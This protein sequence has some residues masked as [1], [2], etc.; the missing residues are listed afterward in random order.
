MVP[1]DIEKATGDICQ[2]GSLLGTQ[3]IN[4]N[5]TGPSHCGAYLLLVEEPDTK[6]LSSTMYT[7]LEE[8]WKHRKETK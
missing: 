4:M 6:N 7:L 5:N 2:V 8:G 3:N 1:I